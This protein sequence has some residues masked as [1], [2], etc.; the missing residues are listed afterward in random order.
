MNIN[1]YIY[2]Y[3]YAC[4]YTN[5][6]MYIIK[7]KEKNQFCDFIVNLFG[8][9]K[10]TFIRC[11]ERK[12]YSCVFEYNLSRFIYQPMGLVVVFANGQGDQGSIS[13]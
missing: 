12:K 4:T 8:S 9:I 1:I 6:Y 7:L 5:I 13:G 11:R 10:M 2:I 3:I